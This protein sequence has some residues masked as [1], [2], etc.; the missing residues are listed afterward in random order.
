MK[1]SPTSQNQFA[2]QMDKLTI[3][4]E[5]VAI[6]NE[7]LEWRLKY[8]TMEGNYQSKIKEL[9]QIVEY[10]KEK[11]RNLEKI[12]PAEDNSNLEI[13]AEY[14]VSPYSQNKNASTATEKQLQT[15]QNEILRL[16]KLVEFEKSK[17]N[18]SFQLVSDNELEKDKY[19]IIKKEN[20]IL[21]KLLDQKAL[22]LANA[23]TSITTLQIELSKLK[24]SQ[25]VSPQQLQMPQIKSEKDNA[26]D[27]SSN[28]IDN[29]FETYELIF[30]E[31]ME[32]IS[33]LSNQRNRLIGLVRSYEQICRA[34]DSAISKLQEGVKTEKIQHI[35]SE[36]KQKVLRDLFHRVT[37]LVQMPDKQLL[38]SPTYDGK[39]LEVIQNLLDDNDELNQ[40]IRIQ[41]NSTGSG[42]NSQSL[43][44]TF[45]SKCYSDANSLSIIEKPS[46]HSIEI[47]NDT[48]EVVLG[49]LKNAF[50]F[51]H[52]LLKSNTSF[53]K[54]EVISK[55]IEI[56]HFLNLQKTPPK[57]I[58]SIFT[59]E[60]TI[61]EQMKTFLR[62]RSNTKK[63]VAKAN[64]DLES[65]QKENDQMIKILYTLFKGVLSINSLL[66][67]RN[68]NLEK[69]NQILNN[70]IVK[71]IA[72]KE[73]TIRKVNER[74]HF[75][76]T[77]ISTQIGQK[78]N[79]NIS[80]EDEIDKLCTEN[81]DLKEE[82]EKQTGII[83]NL[84][85]EIDK[86]LSE[87]EQTKYEHECDLHRVKGQMKRVQRICNQLKQKD[88]TIIAQ[89]RA[90]LD[91]AL[92][93]IKQGN[94]FETDLAEHKKKLSK[95]KEM[96]NELKTLH[97]QLKEEKQLAEQ[98]QLKLNS[99]ESQVRRLTNSIAE[100][101]L[102][103][104]EMKEKLEKVKSA[105]KALKNENCLLN[106]K[107][108]NELVQ[109][110]NRNDEI[111]KEMKTVFDELN[112]EN[113]QLR[114]TITNMSKELVAAEEMK[115]ETVQ[116]V[117]QLSVQLANV[118]VQLKDCQAALKNSQNSSEQRVDAIKSYYD[119]ELTKQKDEMEKCRKQ[120]ITIF[121]IENIDLNA[122]NS[123]TSYTVDSTNVPL[124]ELVNTFVSFYEPQKIKD[125]EKC[126]QI[127]KV[128]SSSSLFTSVK[129]L[130]KSY[131]ECN[132]SLRNAKKEINRVTSNNDKLLSDFDEHKF[133][134]LKDQ[135]ILKRI[136]S[137][138]NL[139]K[140]NSPSANNSVDT[141]SLDYNQMMNEIQEVIYF[142]VINPNSV[143][144]LL[145]ILRAEKMIF[146]NRR[147]NR[148]VFM[149][150]NHP[151]DN[152]HPEVVTIAPLTLTILF[153]L[154]ISKLSGYSH[155]NIDL[156]KIEKK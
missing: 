79:D 78:E 73:A 84:N 98:N 133:R 147:L 32:S 151:K 31:N 143:H 108:Q 15:A 41:S 30:T 61:S 74:L 120:F 63:E 23:E 10:L 44:E 59:N 76:G 131:A 92:E 25:K 3:S 80:L 71:E 64:G 115:K 88:E 119:L 99:A 138:Y 7:N 155:L 141:Y 14:G 60:E 12:S 116:K 106:E 156:K 53:N 118:K 121:S 127:L 94:R 123:L 57:S 28:P 129:S 114:N 91:E 90:E 35:E 117:A 95:Y 77:K 20:E 135:T 18:H 139:L 137:V 85:L 39:I 132:R 68:H 46:S 48:T 56:E 153:V 27:K 70:D 81:A 97:A 148:L 58:A 24:C 145:E 140:K 102:L 69:A 72:I 26:F 65:I 144:F 47:R 5:E 13:F 83:D 17:N 50:D 86:H 107:N 34:E 105:K 67:D 33:Q 146:A 93:T 149:E 1:T 110:R 2:P 130:L 11:N 22:E 89:L 6:R 112:D 21:K 54:E 96:K 45:G 128:K 103:M 122:H 62:I 51:L 109:L 55:C 8:E 38:S 142:N 43:S 104:K 111:Q 49:Q 42:M 29:H 16:R 66:F 19:S 87:I 9:N 113:D 152:Q 37:S 126:R 75:L 101:D 124:N 136:Y 150:S 82:I 125:Y 154:R 134:L 40:L 100:K 52:S 4:D 36:T